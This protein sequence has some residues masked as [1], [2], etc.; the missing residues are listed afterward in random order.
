MMNKDA[1]VLGVLLRL[2]RRRQPAYDD[3]VLA[4]ICATAGEMRSSLRRLRRAE[5]VQISRR[6]LPQLTLAG[7]AMAV[8]LLPARP[9]RDSCDDGVS[10]AA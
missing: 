3:E 8:A 5:L 1:R 9:R 4:R 7:F 2:A 10:R 6:G